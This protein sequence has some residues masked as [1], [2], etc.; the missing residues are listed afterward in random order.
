VDPA[1]RVFVSYIDKTREFY[2]AQGYGTPYR[3]AYNTEVPFAPLAK[4]LA[5]SR[6]GVVTTSSI[7]IG[8]EAMDLADRPPKRAYTAP[9]HPIPARQ[10]TMDLA[11]DKVAT[12]TDDV[13]TFLPLRRLDEFVAEGRVNSASPRFYGV[14]TEYSQRKTTTIDA[15]DILQFCREDGVDVVVLAGL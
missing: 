6:V 1:W 7:D 15:P 4:P 11:W 12:H 13:D 9:A 8:Q 14:P 5:Q 3:W 10:F 2:A